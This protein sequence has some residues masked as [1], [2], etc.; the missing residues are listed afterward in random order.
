MQGRNNKIWM[1]CRMCSLACRGPL[2]ETTCWTRWAI[3]LIWWVLMLLTKHY[4]S[5]HMCKENRNSCLGQRPALFLK[6][7]SFQ[8]S[9]L[10]CTGTLQ[11][12]LSGYERSKLVSFSS[13][14]KMSFPQLVIFFLG[15][16]L[17][18]NHTLLRLP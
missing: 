3:G 2:C 6:L 8:M 18:S 16:N 9:V 11:L 1:S 13:T 4:L 12:L 17:L 7:R 5:E 14:L 10:Q 15:K